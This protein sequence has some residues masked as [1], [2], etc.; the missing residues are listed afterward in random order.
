MKNKQKRLGVITLG[1]KVNQYDTNS[2]VTQFTEAGYELV[3][4]HEEA[5]VYLINTCTV[6]NFGDR[7]SRQMIR[8]AHKQNPDAKVVVMGCL[9]QVAPEKIS[10]LEG[11]S[12][13]VGTSSRDNIVEKVEAAVGA[14]SL[15]AEIRDVTEFEDLPALD[16]S[17]R[18][19]AVLKIQDGCDQFCTY[20]RV[21]FARG[22]SR[23][24]EPESV[25]EQARQLVDH[26]YREIVLTGIHLGLYGRDL[27]DGAPDLAEIAKRIA[28]LP[29]L[30]RLRL[31]SIDPSEVTDELI[32]LV[33][34]HPVL[35]R[36]FHLPLQS[37]SDAVLKRMRRK[38]SRREYLTVVEKVRSRIPEVAITTD[39]MVGFPG[40]TAV[41]FQDTRDLV[42]KASFSKMHVFKYSRRAGTAAARFPEQI[43]AEVKEERSKCLI[44]I[45]EEAAEAF[46]QSLVGQEVL[47][48]VEQVEAG[49]CVGHTDNYVR[50]RF[51]ADAEDLVDTF[52]TVSVIAADSEEVRAQLIRQEGAEMVE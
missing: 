52:V 30:V 2:V 25:L 44:K 23:S 13:L 42:E 27:G 46:H 45:G 38:Y 1:C 3:D 41:D 32:E 34:E 50:V 48:L 19:R 28:D 40:E 11:V 26:G 16:F 22:P 18:T 35:C 9:A 5:D 17:G 21:P 12:L 6:T 24:R 14:A 39:V 4:F 15:V 31:S 49:E 20:C 33:A 37:G 10:A 51:P 29:G 43:P 47:V 7:K 36:H 8:R